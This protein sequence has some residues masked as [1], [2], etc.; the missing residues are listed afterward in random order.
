MEAGSLPGWANVWSPEPGYWRRVG[1]LLAPRIILSRHFDCYR[2][3]IFLGPSA[4]PPKSAVP[5]T[6]QGCRRRLRY[7]RHKKKRLGPHPRLRDRQTRCKGRRGGRHCFRLI[8]T[9]RVVADQGL[10]LQPKVER[11]DDRRQ[12]A[13]KAQA[14]LSSSSR[15]T[16][17]GMTRH[18]PYRTERELAFLRLR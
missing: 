4:T 17:P 16:A 6:I 15:S 1:D 7:W 18:I 11:E 9:M 5:R 3:V 2:I 8:L 10:Q 13:K 12:R 14:D